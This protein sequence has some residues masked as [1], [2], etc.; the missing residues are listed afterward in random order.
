MAIPSDLDSQ[1]GEGRERL[2]DVRR[3]V[4][5]LRREYHRLD[6]VDLAV[7]ELGDPIS[8]QDAL[9]SVQAA[10]GD[11]QSALAMAD[12]AFDVARRYTSRLRESR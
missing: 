3:A 8:A 5:E 7:D 9:G 1:V 11:V 6:A 10:L 4:V 2:R 12:D